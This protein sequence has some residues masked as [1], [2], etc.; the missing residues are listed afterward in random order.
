MLSKKNILFLLLCQFCGLLCAAVS[1]PV[2]I[3]WQAPQTFSLPLESETRLAFEHCCYPQGKLPFYALT[4]P[5]GGN[6]TNYRITINNIQWEA[7]SEQEAHLIAQETL[8]DTLFYFTL[9]TA[10]QHQHQ[11]EIYLLPLFKHNSQI[12]KLRSCSLNLSAQASQRAETSNRYTEQSVL[13]SGRW[14]KIAVDKSGVYRLSYED[15]SAMGFANPANIRLFGYGGKLL[16]EDFNVAVGLHPDDLPEQPIYMDKGSDNVFGPGDFILFYGQGPLQQ[17]YT[18]NGFVFTQHPYSNKGYYFL[19][20]DAGI[21]KTMAWEEDLSA[22]IPDLDIYHTFSAVHSEIEKFNLLESGRTWYGETLTQASPEYSV[23][24]PLKHI[25]TSSNFRLNISTAGYSSTATKA[26]VFVNGA[27]EYNNIL[28]PTTSGSYKAGVT[29]TFNRYVPNTATNNPVIKLQY[30]ANST[31]DKFYVDYITANTYCQLIMDSAQLPICYPKEIGYNIVARYNI[32]T[33]QA[34]TQ[35]W[36]LTQPLAIRRVP[37]QYQNGI[38]SFSTL[39][40]S[41]HHFLAVDITASFPKPSVVGQIPNQNLHSLVQPDMV[42]VAPDQYFDAANLLAQHH[43]QHDNMIVHI[44]TPTQVYNEFS[45]GTP[46]ATAF[47]WLMKMFYDRSAD[48]GKAPQSLLFIGTTSYDNIGRLHQQQVLPSYQ[49]LESLAKNLSYTTD[50]YYGMLDDNEGR[51]IA[52]DKMDIA[53]GRL[54]VRNATEALQVVQKIINYVNNS[55]LGPW[56]NLCAFLGDDE[57]SNVHMIQTDQLSKQLYNT[58]PAYT[59]D[60]VYLDA[61]PMVQEASGGTFPRAKEKILKD[62]DNGVLLFT[63]VGHGSPNT[64]TSERTISLAD[65]CAMDNT[66]LGVWITATCDFSRYDNNSESAGMRVLLNPQGGGVGMLTTTRVVYSSDNFKLASKVFQYIIPSPNQPA[67]TLGEIVRRSKTELGY[68]SNK[69]NFTLLGDPAIKIAYPTYQVITDSINSSIPTEA[70]LNALS[71]VEV[72]GHIATP[73]G[74]SLNNFNGTVHITVYDKQ[75]TINTLNNKGHGVFSYTDYPNILFS[76]KVTVSNGSFAYRFMV[77]KDINYSFGNGRM[78]YYAHSN[79]Q[80]D[81]H[82]VEESFQVGGSDPSYQPTD[83]HPIIRAYLNTPYFTNGS[84]INANPY[85]YAFFNDPYGI[86]VI[87]SG[88]GHDITAELRGPINKT[89]VLNEYYS[90]TLNDF[91]SGTLCYPLAD[92]PNGSYTLKLKAWNLQN[93]SSS[94]L[95]QF[96]VNNQDP[97]GIY[98]FVV[99]PN[100]CSNT[101]N[102]QLVH[103]RPEQLL[104]VEFNIYDTVGRLCAT[105]K[106]S[107]KTQG[108]FGIDPVSVQQLSLNAGIYA[109]KAV[110]STKDGLSCTQTQKFIVAPR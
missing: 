58:D 68:D 19:S 9:S 21:G 40:D 2:N 7:C 39:H 110:L 41:V 101:F 43:R 67:F 23:T 96:N 64:L 69:L 80:Q 15:L 52:S 6:N 45:S 46:D 3:A 49:S 17:T 26:K 29:A 25:D 82:G 16:D 42:I 66:N 1:L 59:I 48:T 34:H 50:D 56:K 35:V 83:N 36:D 104:S 92:L 91:T 63:Y 54:P 99:S 12:C 13:S 89:L 78:V 30:C 5:T 61:F 77:P 33:N 105:L 47:R 94:V 102:I 79:N 60:K 88:I 31:T 108:T 97:P 72:K 10:E 57:D 51:S 28:I 37:T 84:T 85:L 76:G 62:L 8:S 4:I 24:L 11:F 27:E 106:A 98:D 109:I 53:V 81:A 20:C 100:P 14:V 86:N 93:L 75:E 95:L 107:E 87:G 18:D 74:D 73:E 65:I 90:S 103:D 22:M 55:S 70:T 44:I 32:S 71:I 38:L